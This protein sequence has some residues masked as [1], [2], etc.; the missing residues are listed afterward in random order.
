MRQFTETP[1][2]LHMSSIDIAK[3]SQRYGLW[4]MG[5][6]AGGGGGGVLTIGWNDTPLVLSVL[7]CLR[8]SMVSSVGPLW[9]TRRR[10]RVWAD[11]Q[12]ASVC[13]VFF[14]CHF[15][16]RCFGSGVILIVSIPDICVLPHFL[17]SHEYR[18]TR[19]IVYCAILSDQIVF[20][21]P[22][23]VPISY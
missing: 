16:I 12:G 17:Y 22:L 20:G 11:P 14:F 15:P 1:R 8:H 18:L 9:N 4:V 5:R 2:T 13:N 6:V 3:Q 23:G 19:K 7:S 10:P 21:C